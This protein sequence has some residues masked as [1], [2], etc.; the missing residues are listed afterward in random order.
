MG[1]DSVGC[2]LSPLRG[3]EFFPCSGFL[4][5]ELWTCFGLF[6]HRRSLFLQAGHSPRIPSP[7]PDL[8][9]G[10]SRRV[11][12]SRSVGPGRL[13]GP[14]PEATGTGCQVAAGP[15]PPVRSGG[16]LV[17][18]CRV[19]VGVYTG[20]PAIRSGISRVDRIRVSSG[21]ALHPRFGPV[22][23]WLGVG[24]CSD[25]HSGAPIGPLSSDHRS[26]QLPPFWPPIF[27]QF[28]PDPFFGRFSVETWWPSVSYGSPSFLGPSWLVQPAGVAPWFGR[29]FARPARF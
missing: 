21:L 26:F 3:P 17:G 14:F 1:S 5:L 15:S 9:L 10:R 2:S 24:A 7:R 6:S 29:G 16:G 28:S 20:C 25:P 13:V 19:Q 18:G 23:R 12:V 22:V 11:A 27:S 4:R 8:S